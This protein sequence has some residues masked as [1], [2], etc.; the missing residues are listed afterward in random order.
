MTIYLTIY[1]LVRLRTNCSILDALAEYEIPAGEKERC[2]ALREAAMNFD[3]DRFGE[4]L[5]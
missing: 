5:G 4:I 1:A 2:A 3:W